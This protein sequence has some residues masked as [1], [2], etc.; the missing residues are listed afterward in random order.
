[1]DIIY[2]H[3]LE[4]DP[5]DRKPLFRLSDLDTNDPSTLLESAA[6]DDSG[7]PPTKKQKQDKKQQKATSPNLVAMQAH[8]FHLLRP[9]VSKHTN[10]RDALAKSRAGDIPAFENVL[11]LT[12][13]AVKEGLRD[14]ASNPAKYE[15][16]D[17]TLTEQETKPNASEDESSVATVQA[18]K[19]PWWVCQPYVRPLPK[20]AL[21]KGSLTMS[22]KDKKVLEGDLALQKAEAEQ[23]P[24]SERERVDQLDGMP[25]QEIP[26]EAMVCG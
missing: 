14:Y 7:E 24:R 12:E 6:A 9:L 4:K 26:K 25:D 1:M 21:E 5:P 15:I 16:N 23:A 11:R 2:K 19:R 10:I 3:V 18:C 17:H 20:E 8:L 22:K 13:A